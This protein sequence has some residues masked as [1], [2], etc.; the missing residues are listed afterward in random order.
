MT[1]DELK[2]LVEFWAKKSQ[3]GSNPTPDQFN[4]GLLSAFNQW[5]EKERA[6]YEA[7]QESKDN[8]RFLLT[9]KTLIVGQTGVLLIPDGTSVTDVNNAVA[10]EYLQ[11][12]S[13]SY[14]YITE[15][16]DG[17][18]KS[19]EIPIDVVRD[20]EFSH[21][22]S[23]H[24]QP[25]TTRFPIAKELSTTI[26]V[27]PKT[28]QRINLSYL[29]TPLAPKWA[30][31][32]DSSGRPVYDAANSVDLESPSSTHNEIAMMLLSYLG[33]SI[34]EPELQQYAE[35]LKQQTI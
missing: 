4:I 29:K 5:V 33:I 11:L 7:T 8:L 14:N 32:P 16:A 3:S 13:L 9:K 20:Y 2:K 10:P 17:T 18:L 25:P 22:D 28:L 15:N 31:T 30:Y 19:V 6:Q 23:S 12:S 27:R 1:V 26:E 24:L 35:G 34:R 21:R